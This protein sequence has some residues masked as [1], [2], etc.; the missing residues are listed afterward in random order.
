M[1]RS[2]FKERQSFSHRTGIL[3]KDSTKPF[4][5]P[6][7]YVLSKVSFTLHLLQTNFLESSFSITVIIVFSIEKVQ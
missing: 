5:K 7:E 4:M 1:E 2:H 3:K 6:L